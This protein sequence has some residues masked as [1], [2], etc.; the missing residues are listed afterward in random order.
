M[1]DQPMEPE[2][3][4]QAGMERACLKFSQRI[5]S[6]IDQRG[7]SFNVNMRSRYESCDFATK[8]LVISFPVEEYMRNPSGVMHGGAVAGAMDIAMGSLTFYM[9]GETVTPTINMNVSY[10]RPIPTGVRMFVESACLS[11]GK[12]MAYATAR[13]W[14]E[15]QPE[16][17]VASASGTYYTAG[18][19][20]DPKK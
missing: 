10:E 13:A 7:P 17:T 16:K 2:L 4:S 20:G 3:F 12:T 15:G 1:E 11:C 18:G 8:T 14:I 6:E 5:N 19:S 9:S